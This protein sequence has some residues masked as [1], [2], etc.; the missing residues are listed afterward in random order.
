[1]DK[2]I[3]IFVGFDDREKEFYDIC[4]YSLE[5][6]GS[7]VNVHP[8]NHLKLRQEGF[9]TRPWMVD[10]ITGQFIDMVDN[11]PFSTQFS[12]TRFLT[13][14]VAKAMGLTGRALFV[15]LDFLFLDD[16]A[17]ILEEIESQESKPLY[18]V[19]HDYR[20]KNHK[21]MDNK[22]QINY[23]KKLWSSLMVFDID[24]PLNKP[25]TKQYV[26]TSDGRALHTFQWLKEE[27]IGSI[28]ERWNFIEN[29]SEPRVP[30]S[31]IGAIHFTEGVPFMAGY[32][33]GAYADIYYDFKEDF[34]AEQYMQTMEYDAEVIPFKP[35]GK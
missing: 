5:G 3:N 4:K 6:S 10:G 9:F 12:H 33:N 22:E 32:E 25:L 34:L 14:L 8:L 23:D 17:G 24:H 29:H 11:K 28:N 20:P 16:V 21:K 31:S 19:K 35:A 30:F 18:C 27:D 15:D 7:N 2:S 13:P 1:M 26:N